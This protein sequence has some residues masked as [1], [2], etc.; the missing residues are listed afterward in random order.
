[1][2][3]KSGRFE[4]SPALAGELSGWGRIKLSKSNAT[5]PRLLSTATFTST[6]RVRDIL[7]EDDE[8]KDEL[9]NIPPSSSTST[10]A[11]SSRTFSTLLSWIAVP[12][13]GAL[14][15]PFRF[16]ALLSARD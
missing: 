11:S 1:M 6:K 16:R 13:N 14:G 12:R 7:A 9:E 15:T 4:S 3:L 2:A 8:V 10:P 5:E